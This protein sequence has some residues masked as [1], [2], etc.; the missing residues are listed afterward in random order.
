MGVEELLASGKFDPEEIAVAV[1]TGSGFRETEAIA[2]SV[3]LAR[4]PIEPDS[5]TS[6]LENLLRR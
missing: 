2:D 4:V 6:V 1:I 5:G 3:E